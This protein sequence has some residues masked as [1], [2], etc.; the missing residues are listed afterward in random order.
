MVWDDGVLRMLDQRVLPRTETW[1]E[2]R[3][4]EEVAAAVRDMAVR[5]A[6]AIGVA[7]GYGM[8]L[9]ALAGAARATARAGLAAS[10]PTAVNL[11]WALDQTDQAPW[12]PSAVLEVARRIEAD[13]LAMNQAIGRHGAALVP[14]GARVLTVC[15]TG[16]LATAGHGTALGVVRTAYAQGKVRHVFAC[17][18]RPRQQGLRLTAW[19]LM[20]DGI[21]FQVIPDGAAAFLMSK[22]EVDFV[23]VGAD[24]IAANGDTANKI[25]TYTLAVLAR[26]FGVPFTVAAPTSTLDPSTPTGAGIPIEERDPSEVTHVDGVPVGPDRC[27]VWNP[28]FDVTPGDLVTA[29]ITESGVHRGPYRF[30]G[31]SQ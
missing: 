9:A 2:L 23:V 12:D 13:D 15:N 10:R 16:S 20:H 6:P 22:G 24:R 3:T 28:A 4:W 29:I 7:A 25:G 31:H 19:E 14:E 21:P 11:F 17:E 8:A 5:G 1:L 30:M 18:T 27:P 26:H